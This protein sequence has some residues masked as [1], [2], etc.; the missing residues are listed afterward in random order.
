MTVGELTS[1]IG[2]IIAA[3]SGIVALVLQLRRSRPDIR[4]TNAET[5]KLRAETDQTRVEMIRKLADD[6][7][8]QRVE[9]DASRKREDECQ[10]S[11]ESAL[12]QLT[13][14]IARVT[15]MEQFMPAFVMSSK[16]RKRSAGMLRV[17]NA[18]R[19]DAV[20]LS[21]R[22]GLR[23]VWVSNAF[24]S[25]LGR[26]VAGVLAVEWRS[27]IHPADLERTEHIETTAWA[28]GGEWV[29]RLLHANG[30]WLTARWHYSE[31]DEEGFSLSVVWFERRATA[32][33]S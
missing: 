18:I 21:S 27:L 8:A 20:V 29:N 4:R 6:V 14:V 11:L 15:V 28:E 19:T 23:F 33:A 3:V 32:G 1:T 25:A 26:T 7:A 30:S 31:Y 10:A 2:A 24:A 13:E 12:Q 9:I 22:D 17:L 16:I 5:D